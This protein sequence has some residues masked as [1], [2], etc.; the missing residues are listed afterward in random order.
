M[1][2]LTG[3]LPRSLNSEQDISNALTDLLCMFDYSLEFDTDYL[4]FEDE[5]YYEVIHD[6]DFGNWL[7]D[8]SIGE[9]KDLKR[10]LSIKIN[11]S[12]TLPSGYTKGA[13]L[14]NINMYCVGKTSYEFVW[15]IDDYLRFKQICLK[16]ITAKSSFSSELGECFQNIYFDESVPSSINTLNNDFSDIRDEIVDHLRSL[17][18]FHNSFRFHLESGCSFKQLSVLFTQYSGIECSPQAGRDNIASLKKKYLNRDT[19]EQEELTCELHTKFSIHNRD[20]T[21]QDRIYFHPGKP[22]VF[23]GRIIVKH[24]GTHQ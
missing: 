17:D 22:G 1:G 6:T 9:L 15:T 13:F 12:K 21:K 20:A 19:G 5:L 4:V 3:E 8:Y 16:S 23:D 11:Q 7:Y 10:E 2:L 14:T 24:I 18:G